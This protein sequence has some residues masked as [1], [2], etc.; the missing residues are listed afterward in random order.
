MRQLAALKGYR[1]VH[2]RMCMHVRVS[3]YFVQRIALFLIG[4][5]LKAHACAQRQYSHFSSEI[6]F[7]VI[8]V[9]FLFSLLINY[10]SGFIRGV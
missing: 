8:C 2:V 4:K 10:T 9:T 3:I 6:H 5:V 7:A 1:G